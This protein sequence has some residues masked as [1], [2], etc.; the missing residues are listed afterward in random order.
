MSRPCVKVAFADIGT[1][2]FRRSNRCLN[3]EGEMNERV[4]TVIDC[5]QETLVGAGQ[6]EHGIAQLVAIPLADGVRNR[7]VI[8][9]MHLQPKDI[10]GVFP[11]VIRLETTE[12]I[13]PFGMDGVTM[14]RERQFVATTG[15]LFFHLVG[16]NDTE[17]RNT[18]TTIRGRYFV[19]PYFRVAGQ[20]GD[21]ME[22]KRLEIRCG[23]HHRVIAH[24]AVLYLQ[25][26]NNRTIAA[27]AGDSGVGN[28]IV[29]RTE[30]GHS[31][32]CNT[33]TKST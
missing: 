27:G 29:L 31:M 18:V 11:F 24:D 10:D 6:I 13:V 8:R 32:P 16:D 22:L 12:V 15:D 23:H 2:D 4:T 19:T 14:P 21:T 28:A 30:N 33:L 26:Q 1:G 9:G 25:I 3:G 20:D 17:N 5:V 7:D